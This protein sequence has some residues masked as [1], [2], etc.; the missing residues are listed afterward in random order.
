M[1]GVCLQDILRKFWILV[2]QHFGTKV[3]CFKVYSLLRGRVSS[4]R[5][6]WE[7]G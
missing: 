2:L 7:Q 5:R 1:T 4:K 6:Q 3:V